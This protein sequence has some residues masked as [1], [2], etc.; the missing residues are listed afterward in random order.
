MSKKDFLKGKNIINDL[1]KHD[2]G[3]GVVIHKGFVIAIE[4]PEGTDVMLNR[5][6]IL[7]KRLHPNNN[8]EGIL[9]KFPKK[10]QDL[11]IDLPTIGITTIRKCLKIGLK[12]I[13]VK[14]NQN[15]F[16]DQSK[17]ISLANKNNM[18]ISAI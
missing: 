17:C 9:L 8:K 3:Q 13:A 2:V 11:R 10:N 18:F 15:I 4:G 1:S 12:G 16:L 6:R 5:A 14:A 7:L